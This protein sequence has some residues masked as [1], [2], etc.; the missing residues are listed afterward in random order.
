M[1]GVRRMMLFSQ[2]VA[3]VSGIG[4]RLNPGP[5][6]IFS[7][8]PPGLAG[9]GCPLH[10]IFFFVSAESQ[11]TGLNWDSS[12]APYP[13]WPVYLVWDAFFSANSQHQLI[14]ELP[15]SPPLRYISARTY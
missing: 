1:H 4:T 7:Y 10:F 15:P 14:R 9:Y 2:K 8:I 5:N 11:A 12:S 13:L 3:V 6:S